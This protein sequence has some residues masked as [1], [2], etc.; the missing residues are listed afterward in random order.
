MTAEAAQRG[1]QY[2]G[3]GFK[4]LMHRLVGQRWRECG[5]EGYDPSAGEQG[6]GRWTDSSSGPA[7]APASAP[8]GA[9]SCGA[10]QHWH[11]AGRGRSDSPKLSSE[12]E[13]SPCPDP[14]RGVA[15]PSPPLPTPHSQPGEKVETAPVDPAKKKAEQARPAG[16]AGLTL[17]PRPRAAPPAAPPTPPRRVHP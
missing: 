9:L 5:R 10:T 17:R 8:E 12:T 13:P 3:L 16:G 4:S 2:Y 6:P 15:A 14:A 11:E 7:E 1:R